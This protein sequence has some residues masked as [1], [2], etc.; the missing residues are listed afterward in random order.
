MGAFLR[1]KILFL[2]EN[3]LTAWTDVIDLILELASKKSWLREECG[4]VLYAVVRDGLLPH[5][6]LQFPALLLQRLHA[7]KLSKS[8]EGIAIWLTVQ[9]KYPEAPL[10]S[11]VWRHADPLNRKELTQLAKLLCEAFSDQASVNEN[12]M[13]PHISH[14]SPTVHFAWEVVMTHL[15]SAAPSTSVEFFPPK[16][17]VNLEQFWNACVDG[18]LTSQ[19]S[20]TS[21]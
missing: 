9:S 8:P 7:Y 1:S 21:R 3:D 14:W 11:G 6:N 10:L 12:R 13:A 19:V 15:F 2:D 4:F 18:K 5:R 17:R 16:G 20:S